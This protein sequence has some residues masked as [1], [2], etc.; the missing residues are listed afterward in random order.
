MVGCDGGKPPARTAAGV[1]DQRCRNPPPAGSQ[2]CRPVAGPGPSGGRSGCFADVG[3]ALITLA[4][5]PSLAVQGEPG[6]KAAKKGGQARAA[7]SAD[8]AR[9][10]AKACFVNLRDES[11]TVVN[12]SGAVAGIE[13][14]PAAQHDVPSVGGD[15]VGILERVAPSSRLVGAGLVRATTELSPTP[16][17]RSVAAASGKPNDG[18]SSGLWVQGPGTASAGVRASP[19]KTRLGGADASSSSSWMASSGVRSSPSRAT[20]DTNGRMQMPAAW[21]SCQPQSSQKPPP[22]ISMSGTAGPVFA[23]QPADDLARV[24][25]EFVGDLT[26]RPAL[27]V[28][29]DGQSPAP[30]G[31]GGRD[32]R[33]QQ[34]H[35]RVGVQDADI[36][37]I[38]PCFPHGTQAA[39]QAI[40]SNCYLGRCALT[41]TFD[42][43]HL[44]T[45][46]EAN[47]TRE[48]G[49]APT[50]ADSECFQVHPAQSSD[51]PTIES[52]SR[53]RFLIAD[54]ERALADNLCMSGKPTKRTSTPT[55]NLGHRWYFAEHAEAQGKSQADVERA[56]G[57]PRGKVSALWNCKQR[58]NQEA[59]DQL[60][61][62]L[63]LEP[64]EL[65]M[66][67]EEARAIKQLRLAARTITN[68]ELPTS[69]PSSARPLG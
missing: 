37:Q 9:A 58:Y 20:G 43:S 12:Q 18:M 57:W 38:G 5:G 61:T 50:L 49:L 60:A 1:H 35:P 15:A 28:E 59:V 44:A 32:H 3:L 41:P 63:D 45:R 10:S 53:R 33:R 11:G 36:V 51:N 13:R 64:Y 26:V 30:V 17:R 2:G 14:D 31:S 68:S 65:L 56:L 52:T 66:S 39:R 69:R 24:A 6:Q 40:K 25:I 54:R 23:G 47:M 34:G 27:A 29:G 55:A 8:Q 62:W 19:R 67:P 48:R 4:R 16:V 22:P 21:H 46:F 7:T 42:V